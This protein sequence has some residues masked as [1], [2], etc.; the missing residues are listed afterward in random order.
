[1]IDA[2]IQ[3]MQVAGENTTAKNKQKELN[4][5]MKKEMITLN[6]QVS[7]EIGMMVSGL[8]KFKLN[9][10]NTMMKRGLPKITSWFNAMLDNL[11]L[12]KVLGIRLAHL[13]T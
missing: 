7:A 5:L 2:R 9:Q 4:V 8:Q 11:Q 6:S 13:K 10:T 3:Q 12:L 1:M